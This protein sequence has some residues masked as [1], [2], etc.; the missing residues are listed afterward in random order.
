MVV[1]LVNIRSAWNVGSI[2]RSSDAA[3][4][5][6]IF[7]CGITPEPIDRFGNPRKDIAKVALGAEKT[8]SWEKSSRVVKTIDK[9]KKDGYTIIAIEQNKNSCPYDK[10]KPKNKTA[11]VLGNEVKGLPLA[12]LKRADK[13]GEIPM[14]GKKE[15]LNVSVAFGIIVFEMIKK[16]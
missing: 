3:G 5:D 4:I 12:V 1:V 15:S 8:V 14:R 16:T 10:I 9:L 7:L 6:K 2:F 11:I 13:I